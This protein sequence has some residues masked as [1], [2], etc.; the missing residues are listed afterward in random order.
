MESRYLD[1]Q[2]NIPKAIEPLDE[3][4]DLSLEDLENEDDTVLSEA[5][6]RFLRE[7][8]SSPGVT[9]HTNTT[10]TNSYASNPW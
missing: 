4:I 10:H 2:S 7:E 6:G 5:L 3:V 8:H 1:A 9:A